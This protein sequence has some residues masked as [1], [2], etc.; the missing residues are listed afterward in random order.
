ML[1]LGVI[2]SLYLP[3]TK[4]TAEASS[5]ISVAGGWAKVRELLAKRELVIAYT[6]IFAQYFT[7]GGVVTLL[8]LHVRG[9]GMEALHVGMLLAVFAVVFLI[10]QLPVGILSD[11]LGRLRPIMAGMGLSAFALVVMSTVSS[12]SM[13]VIAMAL[14]GIAYGTLFPSISAVVVDSSTSG[15]RGMAT[16]IFHALLTL[17]VGFGAPVMGWLGG[18]AGVKSGLLLTS[19]IMVAALFIILG[20]ARG[21][22][23]A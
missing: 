8:P 12:F 14:Y 1:I 9:L 3:R 15:E 17:G 16:G 22:K 6:A 7:F 13:L 19:V 5:E 11:R 21:H 4:K 10:L 20:L 18:M 2:L 23:Q